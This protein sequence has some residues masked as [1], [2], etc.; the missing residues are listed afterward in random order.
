MRYFLA[1][2][3]F[4]LLGI[5]KGQDTIFYDSNWSHTSSRNLSKYYELVYK[6]NGNKKS[7]RVTTYFKSGKIYS[8]KHYC[9]YK[10]GEF[11]GKL[12]EWYES[13][14]LRREID[15]KNGKLNGRLLTFWDNGKQKRIDL[16]END[17]LIK[18]N[19]FNVNGSETN[20]YN[21]EIHPEFPGGDAALYSYLGRELTY[22]TESR[23][24]GVQG[25]VLL[26]FY[27]NKDGSISDISVIERLNVEL[28][29]EAIR[30]VKNMP[31]WKPGMQDGDTLRV[32]FNLPIKFFLGISR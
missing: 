31:E 3:F 17:K 18:G 11:D 9:D 24:N 27:I 8:E 30:V 20:Y 1:L 28:D 12:K 23:D 2:A 21:Y 25:R 26:R 16:Y 5:T 14:Q 13:G 10:N 7:V 29:N 15:Y 6:E 32:Q 4:T 19:C 22:P